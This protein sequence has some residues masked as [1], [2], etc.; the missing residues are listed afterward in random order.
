MSDIDLGVDVKNATDREL[1]DDLQGM[2]AAGGL[3]PLATNI[4]VG[5]QGI[6]GAFMFDGYSPFWSVDIVCRSSDRAS[7][8]DLLEGSTYL[9]SFGSWLSAL[10]K[11]VRADAFLGFFTDLVLGTSVEVLHRPHELFST[12]LDEWMSR[13]N[14]AL[15]YAIGRDVVQHV[16]SYSR[17]L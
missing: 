17:E 14:D 5:P 4:F 10:K 13:Y 11:S 9:R 12:L 16:Y 7:G 8:A 3:R 2:L 1:Y 6:T 15:R